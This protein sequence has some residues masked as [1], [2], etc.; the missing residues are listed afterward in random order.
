M[1]HA[2]A[3]S[4]IEERRRPVERCRTRPIAH[5]AAEAGVPRA[6]LPTWKNRHDTH[7]EA[8]LQDRPSVPRSSPT[9]LPP[10]VVE[11]IEQRRRDNRWPA[12]RNTLEPARVDPAEGHVPRQATF[13]MFVVGPWTVGNVA[14]SRALW[15]P[16]QCEPQ[17]SER[18]IGRA[19]G[20]RS[21]SHHDG[22]TVGAIGTP[23]RNGADSRLIAVR[24]TQGAHQGRATA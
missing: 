22:V 17:R 20:L 23:M 19:L 12:R 4:H 5:V 1:T 6:C 11:P 7:D 3:P 16:S 10:D 15:A 24:W 13:A 8:E 21:G 2:H 9:Q 14:R 18:R